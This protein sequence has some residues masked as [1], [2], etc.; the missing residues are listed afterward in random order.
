M[1]HSKRLVFFGSGPFA[2][3]ALKALHEVGH[4]IELV[5]TRQPRWEGRAG[6]NQPS[7]VATF[8]H[9]QEIS[10]LPCDDPNHPVFLSQFST[11]EF[12]VGV[13]ADYANLLPQ[14]ILLQPSKGF[15]NIHPSLLPR[16]RGAAPIQRAIMAGDDVTGISI[17]RMTTKLD[18]GPVLA[19]Q[20]MPILPDDT[21]ASLLNRLAKEGAQM[22][23]E[24]LDQIN[25]LKP[26]PINQ[27]ASNYAKKVDKSEARIDWNREAGQLDCLIRG[28]SPSPGAW[29]QIRGTRI[30]LL[31]SCRED[32]CGAPGALLD[33]NLRVACGKG[34]VRIL[35]LQRAGKSPMA[36]AEFVRGFPLRAGE[37]FDLD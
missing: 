26:L 29:S 23:V 32:G 20:A 13:L 11:F 18:A 7:Q 21:F 22:M 19:Q 30:K 8:A 15:L 12:D 4:Q 37:R 6:K 5:C 25:Q 34:A 1:H 17:M 2:L 16:W 3:T 24:S 36:A 35:R 14:E 28:L 33:D 31:A 27:A 10:V 9:E